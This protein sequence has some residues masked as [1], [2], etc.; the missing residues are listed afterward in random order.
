MLY[1]DSD[2]S[3]NSWAE[4]RRLVTQTL[5]D[6]DADIK[7]L[8]KKVDEMHVQTAIELTQLKTKAGIWGAILGIVGSLITTALL[9]V[10]A[11]K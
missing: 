9:E 6:L 10:L 7:E 3:N 2:I 8:T 5:K 1:E 4:Y 11:R